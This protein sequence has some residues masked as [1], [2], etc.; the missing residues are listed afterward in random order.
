MLHSC[1]DGISQVSAKERGTGGAHVDEA[2]DW[3]ARRSFL[4]P[5]VDLH[6]IESIVCWHE[7]GHLIG[8]GLRC[9][10]VDRDQKRASGRGLLQHHT[11]SYMDMASKLF[12]FTFTFT[13]GVDIVWCSAL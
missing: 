5:K 13:S 1:N 8:Q 9:F 10:L 12:T 3:Y 7:Q 4:T 2:A 11:Q 6:V